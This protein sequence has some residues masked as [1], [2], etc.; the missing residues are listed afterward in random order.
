MA[1]RSG[2]LSKREARIWQSYRDVRRELQAAFHLQLSRQQGISAA[3]YAVMVPLSE[4]P[5]G[6]LRTKDLGAA[7][8]WDRSRTSH[9]VTRMVKRGLVARDLYE[10]DARGSVVRLTPAGRAT[11]ERAAPNHVALVRQLFFAPLSND[12]LDALGGMLDRM[13]IAIRQYTAEIAE[14][15]GH[16]GRD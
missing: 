13:L 3:D 7:L 16:I 6:R 8:G 15:G 9:Q 1:R 11:I 2:W 4:A 12:E 14:D 5:D 10:D